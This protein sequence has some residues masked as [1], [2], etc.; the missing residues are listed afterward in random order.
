LND[1][2]HIRQPLSSVL[3]AGDAAAADEQRRAAMVVI[4]AVG[5]I[6]KLQRLMV[7]R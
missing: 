5:S 2:P 3:A 1:L 6:R 4:D 7:A